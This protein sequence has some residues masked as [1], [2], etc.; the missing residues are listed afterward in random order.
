VLA[1]LGH[2][3]AALF[4]A[5]SQVPPVERPEQPNPNATNKTKAAAS[6]DRMETSRGIHTPPQSARF[7]IDI[8]Q[9]AR[10]AA[11]H[12]TGLRLLPAGLVASRRRNERRFR[13]ADAAVQTY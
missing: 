9:L 12:V 4:Q 2:A 5:S 8:R 1:V 10:L 13:L 3:A 7:D 6:T 11:V